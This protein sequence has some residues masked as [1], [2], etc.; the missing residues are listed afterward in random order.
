VGKNLIFTEQEARFLQELVRHRVKFLIVGLSAA[1]L[2]GAPAVTQD[3]DLWFQNLAAPGIAKALRPVGGIYVPPTASTR[4]MFGGDAVALFDIVL[5]MDGLRSFDAEYR[6]ALSFPLG[7]YTVKVLPLKRIIAS[8]KAANRPKDKLSLPVLQDAL[9][10][11]HTRQ[12][13]KPLRMMRKE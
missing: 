2:Q 10:A 8:K 3:V 13:R 9:L 6:D 4:P 11:T 5:T 12:R 1:N 7:R